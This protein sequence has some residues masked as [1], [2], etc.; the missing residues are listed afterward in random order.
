VETLKSLHHPQLERPIEANLAD[1]VHDPLLVRRDQFV[2]K[3]EFI[4]PLVIMH[5]DGGQ[6]VIHTRRQYRGYH[7]TLGPY[8]LPDSS[9]RTMCVHDIVHQFGPSGDLI[10]RKRAD[11]NPSSLTKL[12]E[13]EV[14][15]WEEEKKRRQ[16]EQSSKAPRTNDYAPMERGPQADERYIPLIMDPII[17]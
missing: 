17:Y 15:V 3:A 11:Q 12:T 14:A 4:T 2:S 8:R 7:D 16:I 5:E 13:E 10:E 6:T 1:P 9:I